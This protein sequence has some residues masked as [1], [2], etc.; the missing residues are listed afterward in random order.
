MDCAQTGV[1]SGGGGNSH[2]FAGR[3]VRGTG[4]DPYLLTSELAV[5]AAG[6]H[7]HESLDFSGSGTV[8]PGDSVYSQSS[9]LQNGGENLSGGGGEVRRAVRKGKTQ[10]DRKGDSCADGT[11]KY[12][13]NVEKVC[14]GDFVFDSAYFSAELC[15][16]GPGEL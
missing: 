4:N 8:F 6:T 5:K 12:A 2:R 3:L 1:D 15:L 9:P 7:Q 11:G 14:L 10:K 16:C 13:Q